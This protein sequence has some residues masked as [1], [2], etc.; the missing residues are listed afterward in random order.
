MITKI[1]ERILLAVVLAGFYVVMPGYCADKKDPITDEPLLR[2]G[3]QMS[4]VSITHPVSDFDPYQ[5][6]EPQIMTRGMGYEYPTVPL[7]GFTPYIAV[8]LSNKNADDEFDWEHKLENKY[9]GSPLK[10]GSTIPFV[11]GVLDSGAEVDLIAGSTSSYL[12]LTTQ[13]FNGDTLPIGGVGNDSV[14][15]DITTPI[16]FYMAGLGDID[17]NN[18]IDPN[19]YVGHS[20]NMMISAPAIVCN[21]QEIVSALAGRALVGFYTSVIRNDQ[22]KTVVIDGR[23]YSGPDIQFLPAGTTAIPPYSHIISLGIG[24]GLLPITTASYY[25]YEGFGTL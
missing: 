19:D 14:E 12:G 15:A 1:R 23:S 5:P 16:G 13:Y 2:L 11:I 24:N 7:A 18:Q 22:R 25:Y 8:S 20:N 6:L 4:A 10:P 17:D 9:T 21:E 3:G